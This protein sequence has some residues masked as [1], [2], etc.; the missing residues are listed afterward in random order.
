MAE[1]SIAKNAMFNVLY[2]IMNMVFP[3]VTSVYV[4]HILMAGGIGKVGTAQNIVQ[5]FVLLAPLGIV[6]YGT[7]EIAKIRNQKPLTQKL[8]SELFVINGMSTICFSAIYY[9]MILTVDWF[10]SER[11]LFAVAGLPILFN[12]L[13]IEWYYQGYEEYVYIAIRSVMI[14]FYSLTA[15]MIFVRTPNDYVI[16]ALIYALGIVGNY[17]FNAVNLYRKGVR[18]QIH[19]IQVVQHLKSILILLC[20]NIAVELYTLLDTTMLS[21]QCS[22]EVVGYYTNSVKLVKIV[23]GLIT[24]IGSIL[25]PRLSYYVHMNMK[26]ECNKLISTVTLVMLFFAV[27]CGLGIFILSDKL[28]YVMFG[29]TFMPAV[30]TVRIA[31][32]LIYVL[33]F[34]NLF[35]TQ[36]LLTFNQEKKLLICTSIGAGSNILANAFLI[37]LFQQNGAVIASVGSET[38]VTLFTLVFALKYIKIKINTL[39]VF[40]I[41]LSGAG[42]SLAVSV[43][44]RLIPGNIVCLLISVI[45]GGAIYLIVNIALKTTPT[46]VMLNLIIKKR[47]KVI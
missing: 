29:I 46:Q 18:L 9:I 16:Y 7:R 27:P 26:D 34:S 36:V 31:T 47:G 23:V 12:I 37:P 42:M 6:N 45:C 11:L 24:A 2:R 44:S 15:M 43:I 30:T 20:S 5:Y 3:L 14:K 19:H 4:S 25:L 38:L 8:F 1:K 17:V 32:C 22:D 33:G 10:A 28:V 35:G 21:A 40:K 13:N 41:I 39:D